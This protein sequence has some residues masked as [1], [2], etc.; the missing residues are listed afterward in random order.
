MR[1]VFRENKKMKRFCVFLLC[2]SA[3]FNT[4]CL[5]CQ[6]GDD[7]PV[8][9][10]I[11]FHTSPEKS[12]YSVNEKIGLCFSSVP[13]FSYYREYTFSIKFYKYDEIRDT[14]EPTDE[15]V[16]IE[17][18]EKS[19]SIEFSYDEKDFTENS[20]IAKSFFVKAS[21]IGKFLIILDGEGWH[22]NDKGGKSATGYWKGVYIEVLDDADSFAQ[23]LVNHD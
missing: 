13:D 11:D 4:S 7:D 17:T 6:L 1:M 10:G 20:K 21:K 9:S 19:S 22:Y 2:M 5:W 15:I 18:E 12:Q 3:F 23:T 16:D 14:Y 8:L